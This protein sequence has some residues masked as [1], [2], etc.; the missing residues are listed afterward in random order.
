MKKLFF[1]L[2]LLTLTLTAFSQN[3][4]RDIVHLKNGSIIKG[5][6]IE[7]VP[8]KQ[9]KIE[10]A[11]GSIYV[12]EMNDFE[13]MT[14]EKKSE[15][16]TSN[17][18]EQ[19]YSSPIAKGRIMVSGA[20][21]LSYSSLTKE[22]EFTIDMP[23]GYG[24]GEDETITNETDISGFNFKP[25]IAWFVTDGFAI[26]IAMDYESSKNEY[27]DYETKESTLMI[28]PSLTYF[29]GSSNVKPYLFG[30]YMFGNSKMEHKEGNTTNDSEVKMNGW[31]LGGGFAFFLNQN[32][33]LNLGLGYAEIS[34][35]NEIRSSGTNISGD[36]NTKGTA[37]YGG[38]SVYF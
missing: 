29:F 35:E 18:S 4:Y 10:T 20:S 26:G 11:D 12:Y 22:E 24:L 17:K 13:N 5:I 14:K 36:I 1:T 8:N 6:I 37:L 31:A 32:I 27:E 21:E 38:I 33:S 15:I 34:G 16:Y 3:Y 23:S 28:G 7:Q 19:D 2:I 25:T 30:E 9:I